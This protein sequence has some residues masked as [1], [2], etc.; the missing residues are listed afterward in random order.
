MAQ[1]LISPILKCHNIF[2]TKSVKDWLLSPVERKM[3]K[4]GRLRKKKEDRGKVKEREQAVLAG[5]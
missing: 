2:K 4:K 1:F 5:P 3:R